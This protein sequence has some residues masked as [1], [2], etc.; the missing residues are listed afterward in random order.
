MHTTECPLPQPHHNAKS[1]GP[2]L[3]VEDDALIREVIQEVLEFAGYQVESATS[4]HDGL[5]KVSDVRPALV[6][7]DM[8]MPGLDGWDFAGVVKKAEPDMPIVVMTA[9]D[10]GANWARTI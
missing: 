7:L 9:A 3:V 5:R 10:E 1:R 8:R 6:L 2:V 4:G